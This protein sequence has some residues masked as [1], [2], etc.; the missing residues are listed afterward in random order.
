MR[1]RDGDRA[2]SE[3]FSQQGTEGTTKPENGELTESVAPPDVYRT[4]GACIAAYRRKK[5]IP[6]YDSHTSSWLPVHGNC[7]T[8]SKPTISGKSTQSSHLSSLAQGLSRHF[9][10]PETLRATKNFDDSNVTAVGGFGKVYKGVI[11]QTTKKWPSKD[12]IH[13]QNRELMSS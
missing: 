6:V 3:K 7:H 8:D 10:L 11:D 1:D 4:A 2:T 13:N 9:T 12:Q 5:I